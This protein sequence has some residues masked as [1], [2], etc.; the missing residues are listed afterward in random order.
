MYPIEQGTGHI[1]VYEVRLFL[2]GELWK[3][4]KS[5]ILDGNKGRLFQGIYDP[6]IK[7]RICIMHANKER[8]NKSSLKASLPAH[9]R[10]SSGVCSIPNAHVKYICKMSYPPPP[11]NEGSFARRY[12]ATVLRSRESASASSR[13]SMR[14]VSQLL[15]R[16]ARRKTAA[17]PPVPQQTS[18]SAPADPQRVQSEHVGRKKTTAAAVTDPIV[19]PAYDTKPPTA[20]PEGWIES[21][22]WPEVKAYLC[23]PWPDRER[24]L[25]TICCECKHGVS[26]NGIQWDEDNC[27]IGE[28]LLCG[29]ILC[30]QCLSRP[31]EADK[32]ED[33]IVRIEM[34]NKLDLP[35]HIKIYHEG[36]PQFI[37]PG[38]K[39]HLLCAC[40]KPRTVGDLPRC[41]L[42]GRGRV[43]GWRNS[44]LYR[45][46]KQTA[47][48]V[49]RTLTEGQWR[50]ARCHRCDPKHLDDWGHRKFID[51]IQAFRLQMGLIT[52][53]EAKVPLLEVAEWKKK[54]EAKERKAARVRA[55]DQIVVEQ[56]EPG[57]DKPRVK[58]YVEPQDPRLV[59]FKTPFRRV[60]IVEDD[61]HI[62]WEDRLEAPGQSMAEHKLQRREYGRKRHVFGS[63]RS[64]EPAP[65][66]PARYERDTIAGSADY[67][68][69]VEAP[70]EHPPSS[71]GKE[72]AEA[73]EFSSDQQAEDEAE[74]SEKSTKNAARR[75]LATAWNTGN[76]S[77]RSKTSTRDPMPRRSLR[78]NA[79]RQSRSF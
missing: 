48:F 70:P 75:H 20:T 76:M 42:K 45:D 12:Q 43:F 37:C 77:R 4:T 66:R 53:E 25:R 39:M 74:G 56:S 46:E 7:F 51:D 23:K 14:A 41:P 21:S 54:Q 22:W 1:A 59:G 62:S 24:K 60:I 73:E 6:G 58:S 5:E 44:Q 15:A 67:V 78:L 11:P 9:L 49:Y 50:D 38:C 3:T 79:R 26:T 55:L 34:R 64:T 16:S 63:L 17:A 32:P 30:Q 27:K 47:H 71:R 65:T 52:P 31:P 13:D 18:Q 40:G 33:E 69:E 28:V 10:K 68:E 2:W 35:A 29:H 8:T 61:S 72:K 19:D 36:K 57:K